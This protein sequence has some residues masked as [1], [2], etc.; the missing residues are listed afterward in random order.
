MSESNLKREFS[1]RDVK[2]MRDLITGNFDDRT[3]VQVG[4]EKQ[5]HDYQEGDVWEADGKQWTIKNGIKQTLT[6]F[7]KLKKMVVLPLCCPKCNK[8]IPSDEYNKKMWS[9]HNICLKCVIEMEAEIKR[10]GKWEEYEKQMMNLNKNS[11]VDDFETAIEEF[12]KAKGESYV[13]EQGDVESWGG[14]KINEEEIK[15]VKEYIKKLR[16]TEI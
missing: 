16:E 14:G 6:K 7:D 3:Q 1:Q 11:M 13:T 2:R 4:Y 10:T 8:P 15:Q 5:S 9:I 12:F